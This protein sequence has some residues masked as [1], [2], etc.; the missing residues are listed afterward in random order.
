MFCRARCPFGAASAGEFFGV[1][2]VVSNKKKVGGDSCAGIAADW[3]GLR[4]GC[5]PN[6][7]RFFAKSEETGDHFSG[8][9]V[10]RNLKRATRRV[11]VVPGQDS[12]HIC[13]C[14]RWGLPCRLRH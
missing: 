2:G 6:S 1:L 3:F 12:L 7:V 4:F 10:A 8:I 5:K 14:C 9:P 13:S 11:L